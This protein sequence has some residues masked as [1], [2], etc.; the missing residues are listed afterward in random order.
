MT[1]PVRLLD[2]IVPPR[3]PVNTRIPATLVDRLLDL[4]AEEIRHLWDPWTCHID[5]LPYLAWALSVDIWDATWPEAKKRMVTANAF[6]DHQ[7]KGTLAG[8]QTYLGYRDTIVRH[9]VLP[10]ATVFGV[11]GI[12][13][14]DREAWIAHLPQIRIYPFLTT[15]TALATRAF[16]DGPAGKRFLSNAFAQASNGPN[17]YGRRATFQVPGQPEI[18]AVVNEQPVYGQAPSEIVQVGYT[19]SKRAFLGHAIMGHGFMQAS[20]AGQRVVQVRLSD[21]AGPQYLAASGL[22]LQDI[23]PVRVAQTRTAPAYR[24]FLGRTFW[25]ASLYAEQSYAPRL[26]YDRFAL[27]VPGIDPPLQHGHSFMGFSRFGITPFT[28]ELRLELP[29]KRPRWRAGMGRRSF[30]TGFIKTFDRTPLDNAREAIGRSRS[31]TDTILLDLENYSTVS[32]GQ[33]HKL[34][35]FKLGEIKPRRT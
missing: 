14:A 33:N 3:T 31:L 16:M 15:R 1:Y 27:I 10:P 30:M 34:G 24:R 4:N 29:M 6:R 5:A 26:I 21:G 25:T 35:T 23:A 7:L 11:Q 2:H 13:D 8:I 28:A 22:Q 19:G 20:R 17:L 32:L 12:T 9:V 18:D